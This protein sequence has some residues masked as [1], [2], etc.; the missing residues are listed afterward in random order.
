MKKLFLYILAFVLIAMPSFVWGAGQPQQKVQQF[1]GQWL[2]D[3]DPSKIGAENYKTVQ[4][5]RP[6]ATGYEGVNGYTFI[7]TAKIAATASGFLNGF[8]LQTDRT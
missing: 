2:P 8:Q 7:N 3:A 4:N 6:T 1:N 5:L